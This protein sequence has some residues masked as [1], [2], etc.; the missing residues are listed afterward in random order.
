V[1][2]STTRATTYTNGTLVVGIFD[3]ETLEVLWHGSG[4]TK[5]RDNQSPEQRTDN[6][7]RAVTKILEDF[8][9]PS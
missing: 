2:T 3:R 9:P 4:T 7:N 6:V 5:L 8:P 1:S